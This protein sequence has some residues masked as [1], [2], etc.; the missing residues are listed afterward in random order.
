M[1]KVR[2]KKMEKKV[3]VRYFSETEES[4]KL[5]LEHFQKVKSWWS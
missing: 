4:G 3:R 5:Q 2:V 1:E